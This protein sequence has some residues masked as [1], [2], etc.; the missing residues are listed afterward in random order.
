MIADYEK[1]FI[2]SVLTFG[3]SDVDLD[4]KDFNNKAYGLVWEYIRNQR[5]MDMVDLQHR[6]DESMLVQAM[7]E[8]PTGTNVKKCAVHI[9]KAAHRRR[10]DASICHA[11]RQMD[12]GADL[13]M[14][15]DSLARAFDDVPA[16]DE[17]VP[18]KDVLTEAYDQI[19][20]AYKTKGNV[21]FVPSGFQKIDGWIGGL[22]KNGLIVVA[23]RPSM[24][25][26]AFAMNLA[27][28]AA[29]VDPVLVCSMEM[30]KAQ[31]G[32]R[33][34]ASEALLDLSK[35]MK[36]EMVQDEW[37]R[38]ANTPEQL[39]E[40]KLHINARASRTI[41]CVAA[42]AKRFK[43]KHGKMAA[44]VIDY[45]GLFG[46][47][48]K[49]SKAEKIAQVT[50]AAKILAGE[51]ELDC[52]VIL[53]SQL[54]RDVEKRQDKHPM[55][56]DLRDGGSIE[57]DADQIIFMYRDEYYNEKPDNKGIAEADFAKNRNGPTGV[58]KL[59]WISESTKFTDMEYCDV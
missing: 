25:K 3:G 22:Q 46:M 47:E 27:R 12:A 39:A 51:S 32:M 45:L 53:L 35:M 14:I 2:G 6:F 56:S 1:A 54:N 41:Q 13:A 58:V 26:T 33:L 10:V 57:Q 15:N 7:K 24:G 37:S 40:C 30:S 20:T 9:K 59:N 28:N 36:G 11:K 18:L 31:L 5:T 21:N 17:S 42:E 38:L 52:P 50:R 44:L 23:G 49:E 55:M 48:G 29:F 16:A 19:E 43:R 34:M 4:P 8:T